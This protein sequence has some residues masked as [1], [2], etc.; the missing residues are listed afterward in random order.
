MTVRFRL[1]DPSQPYTLEAPGNGHFCQIHQ[2]ECSLIDAVIRYLVAGVAA[3]ENLVLVTRP[4]RRTVILD[5]LA[6]KGIDVNALVQ[7]R[8]LFFYPSSEILGGILKDGRVDPQRFKEVAPRLLAEPS[9]SGRKRLRL[10]G[11]AV[12]DL[13][14]TGNHAAAVDVEACWNELC[15]TFGLEFSLFCGYLIDALDPRSYSDHLAA[16]GR[17]H[18]LMIPAP[19]DHALHCVLDEAVRDV[20]GSPLAELVGRSSVAYSTDWRT[21]LP[22]VF[23]FG[24]WLHEQHPTAATAV[25]QRAREISVRD[26]R[27]AT[28]A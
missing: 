14:Q 1:P 20:L 11:D 8:R 9:W 13:W 10:Y 21:R 28:I 18:A 26:A 19:E 15:G 12:S 25:L 24:F 2:K 27:D 22:M 17:A 5:W 4:N 23:R 3:G 6:A 16:L 7:N